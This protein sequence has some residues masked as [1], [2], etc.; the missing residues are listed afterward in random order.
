MT[1]VLDSSAV[2]ALLWDEPG[3][4]IVAEALHDAIVS[5]VNVA[6]V[7]S[8]LAE[9]GM[10]KEDVRARFRSLGAKIIAFDD[11]QAYK[12][13]ELRCATRSAGLSI[14]DRACLG[15]A[16]QEG[17]IVLTADK[18]WAAVTVGVEVK[19]IR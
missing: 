15:L 17:A 4:E 7:A 6:E 8:K 18:A 1:I 5:A 14:G 9:R 12:V 2:L 13:G 19:L 10:G 3:H 16:L 11:G